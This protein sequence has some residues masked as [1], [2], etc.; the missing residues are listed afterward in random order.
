MQRIFIL[1]LFI[2][3]I[4]IAQDYS[5][6]LPNAE[7]NKDNR[8]PKAVV[9]ESS[10]LHVFDATFTSVPLAKMEIEK[11]EKILKRTLN[12]REANS[13]DKYNFQLVAVRNKFGEIEVFINGSCRP[14]SFWLQKIV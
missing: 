1:L 13:F 5:I 7:Y 9:L 12:K 10:N 11:I 4:I 2:P 3:K 14:H 8:L 6:P